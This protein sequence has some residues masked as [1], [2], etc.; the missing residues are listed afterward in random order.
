L[1][2]VLHLDVADHLVTDRDFRAFVDGLL[3]FMNPFPERNSVI[4]MD[5]EN[6]FRSPALEDFIVKRYALVLNSL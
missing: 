3:D 2:G 4:V 1:D 6:P 5:S